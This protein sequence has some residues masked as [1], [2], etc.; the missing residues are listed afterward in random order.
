MIIGD[1]GGIAFTYDR[2]HHWRFVENLPIGQFYHVSVDQ[3]VPFNIYGGLQDN[4]SWYGPSTVWE[5]KG[6]LNAHWRRVGGGDGFA[7]TSDPSDARYGYSMSQ[8]G[9]LQRF[10][11]VT[12]N[13]RTI[14]P[15]HPEG[16][17]LRFNWNAGF[18]LDP[19]EPATIY[20]GSQFVHR[21]RD[22]GA[23]WEIISPDLTT[24]DPD[25]QRQMRSGGLTIDATGAENYTTIVSIAPSPV[26]RSVIWV[27][28]DDG[29]VQLTRDGG[30]T[31]RN[32]R[33][34]IP[35]V[36]DGTWVPT[37]EASHH[38]AGTAYVVFDDHR[39]G[40]WETYLYRTED[41]GAHWRRLA[42]EGV[43]G[44]THV[45]RE[46]PVERRL[47][48]LGTEFGLYMSLDRGST[49]SL[50][51]SGVPRVPVRDVAIHPRDGDLVLGTHGRGI[52][53]V[54][55]IRPLRAL[56]GAPDLRTEA[57][58]VFSPPPAL[59]VRI[60][61]GI[62][63]RSTGHAM[64]QGRPRPYGAI[65]TFWAARGGRGV[66]EV[67]D[68]AAARVYR[69]P[70]RAVAGLNRVEWDLRPGAHEGSV[71]L[72]RTA[73][74]PPGV[75]EVA[76]TV[77]DH[78]ARAPLTVRADPRIE[79][80]P[81]ERRLRDDALRTVATWSDSLQALRARLER[82]IRGVGVVLETLP[83]G[84]SATGLRSGGEALRDTL[85]AAR[86]RLF[87]G[88][89][90]QGICGRNTPAAAVGRTQSVLAGLVGAP[91]PN[92]RLRMEQ[93]HRALMGIAGEVG[94]LFRERVRPY[95]RALLDAGYT[96]FGE[97][98]GPEEG[99]GGPPGSSEGGR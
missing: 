35:D 51:T 83:A 39:R 68:A 2:G 10:D 78:T 11:K 73:T 87:T 52:L 67:R 30:V 34:R 40:N 50:W 16:I 90:C 33:G 85:I 60:A 15:V 21:S 65:V 3:A 95:R 66:F 74:V 54:D 70:L 45:V 81:A 1:D 98:D 89:S 97:G 31:W 43:D 93:A 79:V 94:R 4:G 7:V 8:Q 84:D 9:T 99:S 62:G 76:V 18:A 26:E 59:A 55:D 27:G 22:H 17:A 49:W 20:L 37:V 63:Y 75:Y 23:S 5:N 48:F 57:V 28:T 53:V 13:R 36:P 41:Y 69:R 19:W 47:L 6:I 92:D 71:R 46:D 56:A 61:E 64:Q 29:N 44:F 12:G 91:G 42:A 82:A 14:Q 38:D 58:H 96:P 86:E 72:P 25:K 32:V 77:G 88:P 80:S 24:N